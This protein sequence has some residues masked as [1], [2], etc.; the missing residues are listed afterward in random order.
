MEK[1]EREKANCLDPKLLQR[2][3]Y[4]DRIDPAGCFLSLLPDLEML[5]SHNKGKGKA[6]Y[7][8]V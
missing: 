3:G 2:A 8:A 4:S 7:K 1:A 6:Q 5:S